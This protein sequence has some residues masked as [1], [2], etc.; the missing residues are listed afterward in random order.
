MCP[1]QC[2]IINYLIFQNVDTTSKSRALAGD[3]FQELKEMR[4]NHGACF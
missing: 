4:E 3:S 2:L 1:A